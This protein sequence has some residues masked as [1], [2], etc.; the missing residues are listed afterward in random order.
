MKSI[1]NVKSKPWTIRDIEKVTKN[2]KNNQ[3][4]DPNGMINELLKPNIMGKDLKNAILQLMN[5]VKENLF[6][7]EYFQLANISSIFKSKGSR[8]SLES[9]RGIFLLPVLKK[10]FDRLIYEDKYPS[11]DSMMSDSNIGARRGKNI[12]IICLLY[13]V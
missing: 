2:L 6:I 8:F 1:K 5:G 7:P 3:T 11:I 10:V 9:D 13:M 4:R 12:K